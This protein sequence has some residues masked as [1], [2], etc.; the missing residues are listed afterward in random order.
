[1]F[2]TSKK[3]GGNLG[4]LAG[5]DAICQKLSTCAGLGG[6]YKAWLSDTDYPVKD[7]FVHSTVPYYR[8][9]GR[10]V[11]DSFDDLAI[12]KEL[13]AKLNADESGRPVDTYNQTA[14]TH[15][16]TAGESIDKPL[17][18]CDYW[19][20]SKKGK[21]GGTG[22]PDS[23]ADYSWTTSG[24]TECSASLYLYCFEQ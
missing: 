2:I 4:G 12:R 22:Y 20:T 7:R 11:A 15:T 17:E 24:L 19:K 16:T 6:T 9:D 13:N 21:Y 1:V 8:V 14:W 10:K 5:A 23:A 3:F 18:D